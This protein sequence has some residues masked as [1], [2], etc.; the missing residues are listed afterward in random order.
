MG[1]EENNGVPDEENDDGDPVKLGSKLQDEATRAWNIHTA[2]YY[3]AGVPLAPPTAPH[4]THRLL[5]RRKLLSQ[6]G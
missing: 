3:K 2:V 6:P 1:P 5:C 4:R